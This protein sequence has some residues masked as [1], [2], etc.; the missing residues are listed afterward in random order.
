MRKLHATKD[1]RFFN[2]WPGG[3]RAS[4]LGLVKWLLFSRNKYRAEKKKEATFTV[5][6]PD[7][8]RL[9]A[10]GKDY[11]VWLGH[12]TVLLKIAGK[13]LITDPVFWDVNPFIRRKTPLPIDPVS[14]PKIDF[15]LISHGHLDH[16]NTKSI[17]FLRDHSDPAFITGPGFRSLLKR[18][19][20]EK[21]IVLDW[22]EEHRANGLKITSLPAQHWSKRGFFDTN[23]MLWCSFLIEK[24]GFKYYW[25]G[26]SGYFGGFKEIG[27]EFGPMDIL[28]VPIGAYEPRWFMKRNHLNPEEAL[29]AA[30]DLLAKRVIP[31]HWGTFDLSD[32]PLWLPLRRLKEIYD[33]QKDAPLTILGHGEDFIIS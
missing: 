7:F 25:I 32:E 15:C 26:D 12:S 2:P 21:N 18:L 30:R 20:T 29:Q 13:V 23:R 19:G 17:R 8:K 31:I 16:L 1:G 4:Y 33:P 22:W 6:K 28:L 3:S 27:V 5:V 24:N 9:E 10:S 11:L 14:L